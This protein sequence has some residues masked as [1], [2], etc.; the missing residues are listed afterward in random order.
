MPSMTTRGVGFLC[1][2]G[3]LAACCSVERPCV[4]GQV[5]PRPVYF[6]PEAFCALEGQ[7]DGLNH[8]F[9]PYQDAMDRCAF[10][11]RVC[12]RLIRVNEDLQHV[13]AGMISREVAPKSI[14]RQLARIASDLE[15]IESKACVPA[16]PDACAKS[17]R[18]MAAALD[19]QLAGAKNPKPP[20]MRALPLA[21]TPD[22]V[23]DEL[24]ADADQHEAHEA[25]QGIQPVRV[26]PPGDAH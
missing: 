24:H 21:K 5:R 3:A 1:L 14:E 15:W 23:G 4:S 26:Q 11:A 6:A 9:A 20:G 2:L 19:A 22:A 13:N 18:A 8:R 7:I 10:P 12:K 16:P 17:P 25:R